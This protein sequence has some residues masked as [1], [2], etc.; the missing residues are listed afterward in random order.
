MRLVHSK[1]LDLHEFPPNE[2]PPYAILSH[3]WGKEEVSFQDMQAGRAKGMR[4]FAKL[5]WTCQIARGQN[6]D[7]VWVDTCCIDKSS[8]AELSESIN[9]MF[10][11]YTNARVCYAY[12]DDFA[13][14]ADRRVEESSFGSCRWFTRGWTLQELIAPPEVFF[15]ARDWSFMGWRS[16]FSEKIARITSIPVEILAASH[17]NSKMA[18]MRSTSVAQRMSW[19]SKRETTRVEDIA[20]CLLGIFGVSMPL[21]YGE[22]EKAFIRLQEEIMKQSVDHSI[23][24]FSDWYNKGALATGPQSFQFSGSVVAYKNSIS[25]SYSSTN[26][27]ILIDLPVYTSEEINTSSK[28]YDR[29]GMIAILNCHQESDFL[30]DLALWLTPL[31]S[32][33][34]A[35]NHAYKNEF[36][37]ISRYLLSNRQ[38]HMR[39]IYLSTEYI[40]EETLP[41]PYA[42][43]IQR[44]PWNRHGCQL[45]DVHPAQYW[46]KSTKTIQA[47]SRSAYTFSRNYFWFQNWCVACLFE[48]SNGQD[49]NEARR[50]FVLVFGFR[51]D[52]AEPIPSVVPF[53]K[54]HH[55]NR[56]SINLVKI[57][58]RYTRSHLENATKISKSMYGKTLEVHIHKDHVMGDNV[59][60]ID[61]YFRD[62]KRR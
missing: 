13:P 52:G 17:N 24:A 8:S 60:G 34:Y 23:F 35:V 42:F 55:P 20:Y 3:R 46:N 56:K 25:S 5:K 26:K 27:G 61:I 49:R 36:I 6:L 1:T 4:G 53:C 9:S 21:L 59:F 28:Y 43:A 54:L 19:A 57:C 50:P 44:M 7:F 11:W 33:R 12:L 41:P 18:Y 45:A 14:R 47:P 38:E 39:T 51:R 30:H 32:D 48:F 40:K 22:G 62:R 15:Y 58:E 31:G 29:K 10:L 2:I 16:T 37:T